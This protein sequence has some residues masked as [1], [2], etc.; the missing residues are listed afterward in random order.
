MIYAKTLAAD[1]QSSRAQSAWPGRET[2]INKHKRFGKMGKI[3]SSP[4]P[5]QSLFAVQQ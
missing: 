4:R 1:F 5:P 3:D 2:G